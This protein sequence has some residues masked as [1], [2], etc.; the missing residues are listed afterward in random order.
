MVLNI[1]FIDIISVYAP[2]LC[3]HLAF[4]LLSSQI[5]VAFNF[6]LFFIGESNRNA[7]TFLFRAALYVWNASVKA[8]HPLAHIS[9]AQNIFNPFKCLETLAG[10][11]ELRMEL[12]PTGCSLA[13]KSAKWMWRKW[14][15]IATSRRERFESRAGNTSSKWQ[16]ASSW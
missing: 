15:T 9:N 13:I 11:G 1:S 14:A 4:M 5:S 10:V 16:A 6:T 7:P 12:L 2:W 3:L 8:F